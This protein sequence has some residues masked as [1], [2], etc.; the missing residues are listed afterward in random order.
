MTEHDLMP[1]PH[2]EEARILL[3]KIRALRAEIPR[4]TTAGLTK[5]QPLNGM[6]AF[7]D[8]ILESAGTAVQMSSRLETAAGVRALTLRDGLGF[9]TAY[10]PCVREF[11][12]L[13]RLMAHV[14]R[15]ERAK[16]M[17]GALDVYAIARRI[18]KQADGAELLPF[19]EDVRAM[20]KAR[21]ARRTKSDPAPAPDAQAA[22]PSPSEK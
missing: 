16:A 4:L 9:T 1:S 17:A 12:A 18:A 19:I 7:P 6:A 21:R 14:I 11:L 2:A 13:A 22:S 10:A 8:G 3:E 20:L 15:V 5:P